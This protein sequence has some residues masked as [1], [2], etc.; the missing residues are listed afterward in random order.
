MK[1]TRRRFEDAMKENREDC[2]L[3]GRENRRKRSKKLGRERRDGKRKSKD[4][5]E[6]AEVK[7]LMECIKKQRDEEGL[8]VAGEKQ[9]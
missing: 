3:L 1:T 9:Y 6:N 8:Q 7:R 5:V 4:K 2:I